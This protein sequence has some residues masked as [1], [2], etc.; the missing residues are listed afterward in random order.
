M[1][2]CS[3]AHSI[4]FEAA[5]KNAMFCVT[6]AASH[7]KNGYAKCYTSSFPFVIGTEMTDYTISST[8]F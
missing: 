4:F 1:F 6:I 7:R 5:N 8:R 3:F 2:S